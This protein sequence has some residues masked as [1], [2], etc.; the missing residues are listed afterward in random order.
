MLTAIRAWWDREPAQLGP[1]HDRLAP[2]DVTTGDP[3]VL[4][5]PDEVS[6]NIYQSPDGVRSIAFRVND[7]VLPLRVG[8]PFTCTV[9]AITRETTERS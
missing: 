6:L 9:T 1:R 5:A 3:I 2:Q 4:V 7:G 8:A